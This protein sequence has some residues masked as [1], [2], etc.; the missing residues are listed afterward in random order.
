[1]DPSGLPQKR[2]NRSRALSSTSEATFRDPTGELMSVSKAGSS[3]QRS[4]DPGTG[5]S[6]RTGSGLLCA[7]AGAE[8]AS[9]TASVVM[10][11]GTAA[12]VGATA[13]AGTTTDIGWFTDEAI[14]D[15]DFGRSSSS[16]SD[17]L[18]ES[19]SSLVSTENK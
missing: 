4:V 14:D 17:S 2:S 5:L 13:S 6:N 19:G 10:G 18:I 9:T 8:V 1:M 11:C 3:R 7:G 12:V 16:S 15:L